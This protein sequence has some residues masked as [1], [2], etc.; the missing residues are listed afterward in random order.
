MN[1][2][3]YIGGFTVV[4]SYIAAAVAIKK[5][6]DRADAP[7]CALCRAQETGGERFG[8]MDP[9]G[10]PVRSKIQR[11]YFSASDTSE[12]RLEVVVVLEDMSVRRYISTGQRNLMLV[13]IAESID[14]EARRK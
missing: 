4:A 6:A 12:T 8:A 14:A 2:I 3:A 5:L 10:P 7:R 1:P 13:A 9:L 11:L